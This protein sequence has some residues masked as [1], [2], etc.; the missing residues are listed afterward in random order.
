MAVK[1]TI[2]DVEL[3]SV[4]DHQGINMPVPATPDAAP[5]GTDSMVNSMSTTIPVGSRDTSPLSSTRS[6]V[7]R[8]NSASPAVLPTQSTGDQ[9]PPPSKRRKLTFAEKEVLR[10]EKQ[11]KDQQ[12]AEEKARKE[13]EKRIKEEERRIKE[14]ER[15]EKKRLRDAEKQAKDE[16][17]RKREKAKEEEKAKKEKS[18]LRLNSFFTK[19]APPRGGSPYVDRSG[20]SSRRSSVASIDG[21]ASIR[22]SSVPVDHPQQS[23]FDRVFPSFFVHAHTSVAPLNRFVSEEGDPE[24]SRSQIDDALVATQNMGSSGEDG[25]KPSICELL[26]VPARKRR[27]FTHTT[28]S[29][30]KI[31]TKIHG[32]VTHPID[33]T[34][35]ATRPP[36]NPTEL[37]KTVPVKYLRFAEDVRP[38]YIG[39]YSKVPLGQS[40][41]KLPRKPFMRALPATNYD[42]DSEAEWDEPEEG[43]ELDSEGEEEV[44]DEDEGDD[45]EEFLDDDDADKSGVKRRNV[46]GDVEPVFTSLNWEGSAKQKGPRLVPYGDITLDLKSF[47][48]EGLLVDSP[49]PL[50]PY[51][52]SYWPSAGKATIDS[53]TDKS[54]HPASMAPP[55]RIPLNAIHNILPFNPTVLVSKSLDTPSKPQGPKSK[56]SVQSKPIPRELLEEFKKAIDGSDLTKAGLVE[57]LK[58]KYI[59]HLLQRF[60]FEAYTVNRFPQITKGT[61][62]ETIALVAERTGKKEAD[63]RWRLHS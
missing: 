55:P 34:R 52:T 27:K 28:T 10:I 18:Q 2:D 1:R 50:N 41:S 11:Y 17:K 16:E 43:E 20:P 54:V 7:T 44:G 49:W 30:K 13:E 61:V 63:K 4:E 6:S 37:L 23:H 59:S 5:A 25:Q 15:E 42:Y 26:Q 46:M 48:L 39:T 21:A 31:M 3:N 45:M 62:Q 33:L 8:E 38:P 53:S 12:K 24:H 36:S 9:Q 14:E 22:S 51:S 56:A 40:N 29:V 57:V 60:A 58:K 47:R 32:S 35:T 19:P